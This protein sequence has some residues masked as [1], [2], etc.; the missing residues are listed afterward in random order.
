MFK[1]KSGPK[2]IKI[3]A[4]VMRKDG[5]IE[6]LGVIAYQNKSWLKTFVWKLKKWIGGNN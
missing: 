1:T 4:V 3:S 5:R 6:D 2:E